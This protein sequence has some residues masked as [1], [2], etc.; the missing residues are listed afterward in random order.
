VTLILADSDHE[1]KFP[2]QR[3]TVTGGWLR[4]G[5]RGLDCGPHSGYSGLGV[6]LVA[7]VL[8]RV[9]ED[10]HTG[11]VQLAVVQPSKAAEDHRLRLELPFTPE[12]FN[13]RPSLGVDDYLDQA[14]G[15]LSRGCD[16][17]VEPTTAAEVNT[18]HFVQS[19][20][21]L[22]LRVGAVTE[23]VP[24]QGREP[25]AMRLA[26]LRHL[27]GEPVSLETATLDQAEQTLREWRRSVAAWAEHPSAPMHPATLEAARAALDDNLDVPAVLGLLAQLIDNPAVPPG[28][29][30]ETFVFLDHVLALVLALE[31][32]REVGQPLSEP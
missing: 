25:L 17:I 22:T 7:D 15:L 14:A 12:M 30:F 27:R 5:V 20:P 9:V 18:P 6:L 11:H 1:R 28:A 2:R 10:L 19:N 26:L 16:V 4:I 29:K 31:L 3:L 8:R 23:P 32:A 24:A 21:Q 13:I